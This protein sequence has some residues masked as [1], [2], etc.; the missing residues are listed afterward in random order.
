MVI[1]MFGKKNNNI[2]YDSLNEVIRLSKRIL[3]VFFT[4][5]ILSI[6]LIAII[7]F[8]KLKVFKIISNVLKVIAPFFI[9]L[10]IAWLLDP[11]VTFLQ[12]KKIKRGLGTIIVVLVFGALIFLLFRTLIP[13]LFKQLYEFIDNVPELMSSISKFMN[14]LFNKFSK[15]GFDFS[16]VEANL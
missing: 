10:A 5:L 16:S 9:G 4:I 11:L 15:S 8:D 13:L 12:K 6:I 1:V 7:L 2:D 3:R 14:D